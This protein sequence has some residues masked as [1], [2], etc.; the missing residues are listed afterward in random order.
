MTVPSAVP[1]EYPRS[2][3]AVGALTLIGRPKFDMSTTAT[4]DLICAPTFAPAM[5]MFSTDGAGTQLICLPVQSL[6]SKAM[7]LLQIFVST[8]VRAARGHYPKPRLYW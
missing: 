1:C 8:V 7:Y 3:T 4:A 5:A 2:Y 6:R